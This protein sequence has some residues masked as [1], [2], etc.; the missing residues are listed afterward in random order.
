MAM[1]TYQDWHWGSPTSGIDRSETDA[2]DSVDHNEA[3]AKLDFTL[4][5]D[6]RRLHPS[7]RH[8]VRPRTSMIRRL[9]NYDRSKSPGHQLTSAYFGTG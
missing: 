3:K 1:H 8:T 4:S 5:L 2:A 6:F 7:D 9:C